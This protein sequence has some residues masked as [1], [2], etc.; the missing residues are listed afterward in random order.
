MAGQEASRMGLPGGAIVLSRE[1]G[2]H[3][4]MGSLHAVFKA[5][6]AETQERYSVSEWW[7]RPRTLGPGGHR[8]EDNDEVFY[9]LE[10]RPELLV[11]EDWV[12]LERGGFALIPRRVTHDFRNTTEEE[13]GL[14]NLFIPG[15][16]ERDMPNIVRWFE[17]NR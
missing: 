17:E 11:G 3:Y 10:G 5:D 16:F 13:A 2:R 14:L 15:G 9:V 1:G 4:E 6:E 8:H 7:L 12:A